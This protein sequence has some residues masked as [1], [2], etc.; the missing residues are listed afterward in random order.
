MNHSS[1]SKHLKPNSLIRLRTAFLTICLLVLLF[2]LSSILIVR[3][4]N[5]KLSVST[6]HTMKQEQVFRQESIEQQILL[7]SARE[8]LRKLAQEIEI[9]Q[10]LKAKYQNDFNLRYKATEE[11]HLLAEKSLSEALQSGHNMANE[12]DSA[13]AKV[14]FMQT[15]LNEADHRFLESRRTKILELARWLART[16]KST[17]PDGDQELAALLALQAYRINVENGGDA[18][19][20]EIFN[21]LSEKAGAPL[22]LGGKSDVIRAMVWSNHSNSIFAT[23]DDGFIT[24]WCPQDENGG[25]YS[26]AEVEFKDTQIR[27]IAIDNQTDMIFAGTADGRIIKWDINDSIILP[28]IISAHKGVVSALSLSADK[29]SIFSAGHDGQVSQWN[30]NGDLI[31]H[32]QFPDRKLRVN[33]ICAHPKADIISWA[34]STGVLSFSSES[35]ETIKRLNLDKPATS[36][37]FSTDGSMFFCG[38]SNGELMVFSYPT[39]NLLS[40]K[41]P[42]RAGINQIIVHPTRPLIG[43]CSYDGIILLHKT[44][45]LQASPLQLIDQKT[46]VYAIAFSPDGKHLAGSGKNKAVCLYPIDSEELVKKVCLSAKRSLSMDE[47]NRFIG[48]TLPYNPVCNESL[49]TKSLKR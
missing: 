2:L 27:A 6:A 19:N 14:Q 4:F 10:E 26:C 43:S 40:K 13:L 21:A 25:F 11:K 39:L 9:Q 22:T 15:Q 35:G 45:Q 20:D 31:R 42:H 17:G 41:K 34:N 28:M 38:T 3:H 18:D 5:R 33:T 29:N 12:R 32:L 23:G 37:C 49:D 7:D 47:W 1:V 44:D 8:H 36:I 46:W 30:L 48:N 16:A 24:R